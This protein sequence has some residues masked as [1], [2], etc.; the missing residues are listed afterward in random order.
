MEEALRRRAV[1]HAFELNGFLD[2]TVG[3]RNDSRGYADLMLGANYT[4][5]VD[6]SRDIRALPPI[7][8]QPALAEAMFAFTESSA[9]RP[10]PRARLYW[11]IDVLAGHAGGRKELWEKVHWSKRKRSRLTRALQYHRHP[12]HQ[13]VLTEAECRLMTKELIIDYAASLGLPLR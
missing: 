3:K 8:A 6:L 1:A 2:I 12:G 7:A 13:P 9:G 5:S 11:V 10:Y 4:D